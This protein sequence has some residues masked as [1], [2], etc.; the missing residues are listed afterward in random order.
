MDRPAATSQAHRTLTV[1]LAVLVATF[2]FRPSAYVAAASYPACTIVGTSDS[3]VLH[4]TSGDDVICTGGGDDSVDA[5]AGNDIVL[6]QGGRITAHLGEGDDR[7]DGAGTSSAH[8]YGEGGNDYI[9]GSDGEDDLDGGPGTD[10]ILGASGDDSIDGGESADDLAGGPGA[11]DIFGESGDDSIDGGDGNDQLSGDN[12]DD[13]IFGEVGDDFLSGGDGDDAL[14]GGSGSNLCGTEPGYEYLP[15][16][17]FDDERPVILSTSFAKSSVEVGESSDYVLAEVVVEDRSPLQHLEVQCDLYG[18]QNASPASVQVNRSSGGTRGYSMFTL[19]GGFSEEEMLNP[20]IMRV[21]TS[22]RVSMPLIFQKGSMPGDY[23]CRVTAVDFFDN[24][25]T[26]RS[27]DET[28]PGIPTMRVVRSAGEW[29]D[30]P[31]VLQSI[32]FDRQSVDVTDGDATL[33]VTVHV[34]DA[35]QVSGVNL[36][37][38]S[39]ADPG[40]SMIQ[41]GIFFENRAGTSGYLKA[42]SSRQVRSVPVP[43]EISGTPRDLTAS[44]DLVFAHGTVPGSLWCFLSL[45]DSA[46]RWISSGNSNWPGP[47]IPALVVERRGTGWDDAPPRLISLSFDHDIVDVSMGD[48]TLFA[49]VEIEDATAVHDG[50]IACS[51]EGGETSAYASFAEDDSVTGSGYRSTDAY[52]RSPSTDPALF[53][54]GKTRLSIKLPITFRGTSKPGLITCRF[55]VSDALGHAATQFDLPDL[56]V[57]RLPAPRELTAAAVSS[58]T[59]GLSWVVPLHNGG[60]EIVD[61]DVEVS[62]DNGLTWDGVPHPPSTVRGMKV[63]GL[64]KGRT[65]LFRVAAI[66]GNGEGTFSQPV[67]VTTLATPPGVPTALTA[68]GVTTNS[69]TLRWAH[70]VDRGGTAI[71]DYVVETSRD[72]GVTWRIVPHVPLASPTLNLVGLAPGTRYLVRIA[73]KNSLGTGARLVGAFSTGSGLAMAP[74]DPQVLKLQ[75]WSLTLSWTLPVSNGG[76][77]IVDYRIQVSTNGGSSWKT[78]T[79]SVS[80]RRTFQVR[81]LQ[82]E[83]EYRFRVAA[84]NGNGIGTYVTLAPVITPSTA[85]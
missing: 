38:A 14:D 13:A 63:S 80:N 73:A 36:Y 48:A 81:G 40:S 2:T 19:N 55:D 5:G 7:F 22:Y 33:G 50:V 57:N 65:Y 75:P 6:A 58:T 47:K 8:V 12:G 68:T 3:E 51:S 25:T 71:T 56:R 83:T 44:F 67:S 43:A 84:V 76:S 45:H 15:G 70:P 77:P 17:T 34:T 52:N 10:T 74:R 62:R 64:A 61:Y 39:L 79:H 41:G 60:A 59:L 20:D 16:C 23:R 53:S 26:R 30:D 29:D 78:L 37:C 69:A 31:P 32:V 24:S 28:T 54:G 72:G 85:P 4:G 11:D 1:L 82:P 27:S 66:N 42:Y 35:T 9:L 49:T 18:W 21:G 46:S